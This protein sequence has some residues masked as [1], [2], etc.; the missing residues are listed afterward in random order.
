M[1]R[2]CLPKYIPNF[3]KRT[4]RKC[5][6]IFA[7]L[8][9]F[10]FSLQAQMWNGQDT[11]YGNEWIDYAKAYYKIPVAEDGIYRISSAVLLQSGLPLNDLTGEQFRLFHLGKEIPLYLSTTD[12]LSVNDYIVFYGKK[13]RGGLD[14]HLFK[15]PNVQMLNPRYSMY[16][17]TAM[18]YLTW[19][20]PGTSGKRYQTIQMDLTNLPE[21]E[22]H[23]L[24]QAQVVFNNRYSK[25]YTRISGVSLYRSDFT[26][27]EGFGSGSSEDLFRL[28]S[29][30]NKHRKNFKVALPALAPQ[31]IDGT[32]RLRF[33]CGPGTH[34][35]ILQINGAT[36]GEFKFNGFQ[37]KDTTLA[38][39]AA[40]L[41]DNLDVQLEGQI[42]NLN[43]G[44]ETTQDGQTIAFAE[45]TYPRTFDF[46]NKPVFF[47]N[48]SASTTNRHL[49]ITRFSVLRSSFVS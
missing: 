5:I 13:N 31:S 22:P 41:N 46:Q 16:T 11:L 7:L 14:R 20:P 38:I 44:T 12:L 37:V 2:T 9:S 25:T 4:T 24:D 33:G 1:D 17:D 48:L 45:V 15:D 29:S 21:P 39:P 30:P 49:E 3:L 18:Y 42:T 36:Y 35:Q 27:V 23:F 28:L 32:L 47:F 34:H 10:S 8:L 19:A 6:L 43:N 40:V 26:A